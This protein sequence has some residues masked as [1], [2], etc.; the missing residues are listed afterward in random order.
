MAPPNKGDQEKAR[1]INEFFTRA[2]YP[3]KA[4]RFGK[5]EPFRV[6]WGFPTEQSVVVYIFC[7]CDRV[8]SW[9]WSKGESQ[10]TLNDKRIYYEELCFVTSQNCF[11]FYDSWV[12][13]IGSSV[14][15]YFYEA[16][17]SKCTFFEYFSLWSPMWLTIV[18]RVAVVIII[19]PPAVI[20]NT[21]LR[22]FIYI[23]LFLPWI[24][25]FYVCEHFSVFCKLIWFA[26]AYEIWFMHILKT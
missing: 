23:Y 18:M 14:I 17:V 10:H 6:A 16:L 8:Q 19:S 24:L 22:K 1:N 13:T 5:A 2:C 3:M 4:S 7:V 9:H 12:H 11:A 25:L 26:V 20:S 15:G 21:N